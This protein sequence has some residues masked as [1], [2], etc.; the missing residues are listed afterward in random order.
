MVE[1]LNTNFP[2]SGFFIAQYYCDFYHVIAIKIVVW[3]VFVPNLELEVVLSEP[4][5]GDV[6]LVLVGSKFG[7]LYIS[8]FCSVYQTD[9][10]P[11]FLSIRSPCLLLS[12]VP[13][14]FYF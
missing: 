4:L 11:P 3:V 13:S 14:L 10:V 9:F 12:V 6:G 7:I 2:N 5:V 8:G 1:K